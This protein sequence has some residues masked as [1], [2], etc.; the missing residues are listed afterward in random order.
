MIWIKIDLNGCLILPQ[1]FKD[2]ESLVDF[3]A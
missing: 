3:L 1:K 2:S